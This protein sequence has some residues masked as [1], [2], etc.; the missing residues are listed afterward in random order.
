MPP[1]SKN[2]PRFFDYRR[3]PLPLDIALS[4]AL[5][6]PSDDTRSARAL[7]LAG[8]VRVN[9]ETQTNRHRLVC[10]RG[11]R[12]SWV[13]PDEEGTNNWKG[14]VTG[15]QPV[16]SIALPRYFVCYKPRGVTCSSGHEETERGDAVLISEW[17]ARIATAVDDNIDVLRSDLPSGDNPGAVCDRKQGASGKAIKTVGRLDKESEGLI[18]LTNDG[19]FSRLLCDPEFGLRKTYRVVVRG[20]AYHK[21]V[22][23]AGHCPSGD[24]FANH[25]ADKEITEEEQSVTSSDKDILSK[26]VMEAIQLGNLGP[27]PAQHTTARTIS[28][29][30]KHHDENIAAVTPCFPFESCSILD[31]GRLPAQHPSDDSYYALV[32]LVL[33][34]GKRHAVRRLARNAGLRVLYLSRVAVEGLEGVCGVIRPRSLAEAAGEGFLAPGGRR[35]STAVPAGKLV[36]PP[37]GS[38]GR[39]AVVGIDG[40]RADCDAANGDT[41]CK[42]H[43]SIALLRPGDV[44]ELRECDV[45]R[46]FDLRKVVI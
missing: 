37:G 24:E 15:E 29:G 18:L 44:M 19:S 34:E 43:C 4:F 5:P 41:S 20:S 22:A 31:A 42:D 17:L 27:S 2:A 35:R 25:D 1:P 11:D 23:G 36:S 39:H 33:R 21:M 32:D 13:G 16:R 38:V 6:S 28:G 9:G 14:A 7:V 46:I 10:R 30:V 45:D 40:C 8:K 3:S 12:L 26:R